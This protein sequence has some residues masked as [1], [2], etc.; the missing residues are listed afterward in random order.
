MNTHSGIVNADSDNHTKIVHNQSEYAI[1]APLS[2]LPSTDIVQEPLESSVMR[3]MTEL[4]LPGTEDGKIGANNYTPLVYTL[5]NSPSLKKI[6][7]RKNNLYGESLTLVCNALK[8]LSD[9][10]SLEL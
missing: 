5:E 4:I 8:R 6:E 9:L 7:L 10:E 1:L 3:E 2:L